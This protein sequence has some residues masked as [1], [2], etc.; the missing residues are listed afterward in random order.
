MKRSCHWGKNFFLLGWEWVT[1]YPRVFFLFFF[2]SYASLTWPLVW[3][4]SV[5]ICLLSVCPHREPGWADLRA[6]HSGAARCDGQADEGWG[7]WI[8]LF[9]CN[10]NPK[11]GSGYDVC[12]GVCVRTRPCLT[13][14]SQ[15]PLAAVTDSKP[16]ER[17]SS[18]WMRGGGSEGAWGRGLSHCIQMPVLNCSNRAGYL[19]WARRLN[20]TPMP[21]DYCIQPAVFVLV[22][23][24]QG[25]EN[26]SVTSGLE[27]VLVKD[28]M[29]NGS[30]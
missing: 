23:A 25:V 15:L 5:S 18:K 26:I 10:P 8:P 2:F 30:R 27:L 29:Q 6:Q 13:P 14:H 24:V 22:V 11:W 12:V 1:A 16:G 19:V 17:T 9:Q 4:G 21:A 3:M 20:S 7:S 28:F